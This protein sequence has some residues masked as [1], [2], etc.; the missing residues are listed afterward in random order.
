MT[1]T[2]LP[3]KGTETR[4]CEQVML[5]IQPMRSSSSVSGF[6]FSLTM[7]LPAGSF[8]HELNSFSPGSSDPPG[9]P[10]VAVAAGVAGAGGLASSGF[11][12]GNLGNK[13]VGRGGAG[14]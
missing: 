14:G 5:E 10:G 7:R 2:F 1:V 12:V 9:A 3:C 4:N 11:A 13:R 6:R 8:L